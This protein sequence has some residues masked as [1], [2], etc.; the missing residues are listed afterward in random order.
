M[1]ED[2]GF[3][4]FDFI[5]DLKYYEDIWN[6]ILYQFVEAKR[7]ER[8]YQPCKRYRHK[9]SYRD[10]GDDVESDFNIQ[11]ANLTDDDIRTICEIY[12][13]DYICFPF[14]IPNQCNITDLFVKHYN[15]HV[16]YNDCYFH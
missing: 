16:S 15:K 11:R 5:G 8:R 10:Y 12:W 2:L 4:P 1:R 6:P 13:I 14:E 7:K 9:D 3:Y